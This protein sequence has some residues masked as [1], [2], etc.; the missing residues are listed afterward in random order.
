[1]AA[2]ECGHMTALKQYQRLE[3]SGLWR[4]AG[5]AQRRE[6]VVEFGDATLVIAD[7]A[8]RALTHWSLPAL[9]RLNPGE[10][11]ARFSPDDEGTETLEIDD[12][13]MID[14]IEKVRRSIERRRPRPGRLRNWIIGAVILA[15]L[16]LGVFWMPDALI[17]QTLRA[18][19]QAKRV[20][21]G[22]TL[23]GHIQRLTG[24]A[25]RTSAGLAA[26]ERLGARVLGPDARPQIVVVPDAMPQAVVLPGGIYI[27]EVAHILD[28]D[29]PAVTA[30]HLLAANARLGGADS[31]EAILVSAGLSANL[32]LMATG[33]LPESALRSHAADLLSAPAEKPAD[34]ALLAAFA[35]AEIPSSPYAWALDVTGE[36]TLGLIEADPM[37]GLQVPAILSDHDWVA[38]Q[39][40]CG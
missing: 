18:V 38:L 11:P 5:S 12:D 32:Q 33:D 14:A 10:R 6:V 16:G 19:P 9:V 39:S 26:L 36:S 23:L 21:I 13:L 1:M 2:K 30:G 40:V 25:C 28:A 15:M 37:S 24:P 29:D 4:G 8:G 35:A 27:I 3:S 34:E 20:E 17:R 7:S 31:L 22:A